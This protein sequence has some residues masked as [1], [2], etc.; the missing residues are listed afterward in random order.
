MV[1]GKWTS[2][3]HRDPRIED[4]TG[5]GRWSGISVTGKMNRTISI[6]VGYRTC[7]GSRLSAGLG[8]TYHREHEFLAEKNQIKSPNPRKAFLQDLETTILQLRGQGHAIIV[9]LDA[10]ETL[11][12]EN[13]LG[14]WKARLDLQDV[15]QTCPA[16]STYIGST[17]RRIDFMFACTQ[18]MPH[19]KAS[20]ILSY[21]EGPQSDHRGIFLDIDIAAY[22]QYD[23]G[24][25]PMISSALRTLRTGNPEMVAGYHRAMHRYYIDHIYI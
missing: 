3:I 2:T 21:M 18:A 19:I 22:I 12:N 5:L 20:G 9:M 24:K 15:H 16:P 6:I 10:N 23:A 8:T 11:R 7:K 4:K 14:K 1:Q 13:D 25:N 17:S